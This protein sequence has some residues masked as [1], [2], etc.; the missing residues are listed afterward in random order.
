MLRPHTPYLLCAEYIADV[1]CCHATAAYTHFSTC[2]AA[3]YDQFA[4]PEALAQ[5]VHSRQAGGLT[6]RYFGAALERL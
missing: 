2:R 3:E 6:P 1:E 5:A 4:I